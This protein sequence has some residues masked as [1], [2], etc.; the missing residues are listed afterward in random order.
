[1]LFLVGANRHQIGLVKQDVG[2]HEHRIGE[3]PA[4]ILS[5]CLR[6]FP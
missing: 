4:L 6:D 3:K 2:G 1:V 5:A